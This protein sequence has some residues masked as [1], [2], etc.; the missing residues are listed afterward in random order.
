MMTMDK[1]VRLRALAV[2]KYFHVILLHVRLHEFA[3]GIMIT[4]AVECW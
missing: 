1:I 2:A 4:G 3:V